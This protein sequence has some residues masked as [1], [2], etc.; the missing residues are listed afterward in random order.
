M[1]HIVTPGALNG[2][3]G[4][5]GFGKG[6]GTAIRNGLGF[7]GRGGSFLGSK[8]TM[9]GLL[10]NVFF[11]KNLHTWHIRR[12]DDP[13]TIPLPS[14]RDAIDGQNPVACQNRFTIPYYLLCA[15]SV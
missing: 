7:G 6:D 8:R 11:G 15:A 14:G 9:A 3:G 4:F 12:L 2:G 13:I 1:L 5:W 10:N